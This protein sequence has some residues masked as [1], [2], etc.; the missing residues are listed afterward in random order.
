MT[1]DRAFLAGIVADPDDDAV[2][3]VY[4]DRLDERGESARAE[5][6]RLQVK[7]ART[8]VADPRHDELAERERQLLRAHAEGWRAA[9]PKVPHLYWGDFRRGFV[10]EVKLIEL[11]EEDLYDYPGLTFPDGCRIDALVPREKLAA[12]FDAAPVRRL[13]L[14]IYHRT[15]LGRIAAAL[16][17]SGVKELALSG[18][19]DVSELLAW[20][21]APSSAPVTALDLYPD[22][23]PEAELR[24]LLASPHL[25]RLRSLGLGP[26]PV[27]GP[28]AVELAAA[29]A[30]AN[31]AT[32]HLGDPGN[33][34]GERIGDA[35]L[36]ALAAS[37]T[38]K[39]LREL[40]LPRCRV[41]PT[42]VQALAN[43]PTF[44]GLTRLSLA[45]N[46]L[47]QEGGDALAHSPYL[48]RLVGLDLSL[49]GV[50]PAGLAAMTSS[51]T[52]AAVR[53]LN[54]GGNHGNGDL[55]P[56][57]AAARHWRLTRLDL[58][59]VHVSPGGAAALAAAPSLAGLVS[60]DLRG[61]PTLG[62]DG[63][64][65][66][67]S[68]PAWA[69][70]RS[71][72]LSSCSVDPAVVAAFAATGGLRKLHTLDLGFN[73]FGDDGAAALARWPGLAGLGVLDLAYC[74]IGEAGAQAL[75]D[76]PWLRPGVNLVLFGNDR[77]SK[78]T[79]GA[80]RDRYG[81]GVWWSDGP[82]EGY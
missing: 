6:I 26:T 66:L 42:G 48:S 76:S 12:A 51:P 49:C 10:E 13:D 54:L 64:A 41:T 69:G 79:A 28:L 77:I 22:R 20:L 82:P 62:A 5:F 72:D 65:A 17:L 37:G 24:R 32:L 61:N 38:L 68:A 52:L 67:G 1:E 3:L 21:A 39:G 58:I 45:G 73:E 29:P 35:G 15:G 63:I 18:S 60:L 2:R 33:D 57:L 30:L 19:L 4:A 43:S 8:S 70:L 9:L 59:G 11:V 34:R 53:W 16:D 50:T 81:A 71:L 56:A 25:A 55:V 46:R 75:L 23:L 78:R 27:T 36:Q 7:L 14:S 40:Y 44:S 80:L 47:G 74:A 31:L